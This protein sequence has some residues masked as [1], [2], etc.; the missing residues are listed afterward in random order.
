MIEG[1]LFLQTNPGLQNTLPPSGHFFQGFFARFL[2][3]SSSLIFFMK[4]WKLIS[5]L[6]PSAPF[7]P[8]TAAS[9]SLPR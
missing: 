3:H 9:S 1:L 6:L 8:F 7:L 4:L 5:M 2:S